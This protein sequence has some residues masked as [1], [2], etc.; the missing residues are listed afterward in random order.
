MTFT[1][2][3]YMT[4]SP[5]KA[6]GASTSTTIPNIRRPRALLCISAKYLCLNYNPLTQRLRPLGRKIRR[7]AKKVYHVA[8]FLILN[9][10]SLRLAK[11]RIHSHQMH[12]NQPSPS[13]SQLNNPAIYAAPPPAK[14]S[15][16]KGSGS[17]TPPEVPPRPDPLTV[18]VGMF[19][20]W[21][22]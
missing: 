14:L 13:P 10:L 7:K 11:K 1:N 22:K 19:D 6:P 18:V 17:P 21:R 8:F 9:S 4:P 12:P 5:P 3:S 15:R 2:T 16:K 20:K